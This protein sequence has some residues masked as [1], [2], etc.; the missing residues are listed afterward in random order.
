MLA[1][2]MIMHY[3]FRGKPSADECHGKMG[4]RLGV[5]AVSY[6]TVKVRFLQFKSRN[7]CAEGEP[8]SDRL[9]ENGCTQLKQTID[10]DRNVSSQT[11]A[12][13]LKRLIK[14]IINAL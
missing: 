5:N 10:K 11:I 1:D 4:K 2:E 8:H 12:V 14:I 9:I 7:F 3:E 6:D 13:V